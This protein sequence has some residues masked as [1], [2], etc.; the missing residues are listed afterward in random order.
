MCNAYL[1]WHFPQVVEN[2]FIKIRFV[3]DF[4]NQLFP[5]IA[6]LGFLLS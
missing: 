3:Y 6:L 2:I 4:L 5:I 1:I